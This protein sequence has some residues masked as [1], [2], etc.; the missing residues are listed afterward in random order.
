[1]AS[2]AIHGAAAALFVFAC[3]CA[4]FA[5]GLAGWAPGLVYVAYDLILAAIV[6]AAT[7]PAIVAPQTA[8]PRP[9]LAAIV[10]AHNEAAALPPTLRALLAQT[11]PPD[12]ILIADD[13]SA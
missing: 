9:T 8:G 6:F 2:L 11:D 1:M 12:L 13:G 3:A 5:P 10:A 7:R 4:V